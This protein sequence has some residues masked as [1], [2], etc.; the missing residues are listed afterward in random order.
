MKREIK[1]R[2]YAKHDEKMV[3]DIQNI[4]SDDASFGR[5]F[6]QSGQWEVMQFTGLLDKNGNEIYEGDI[7]DSET[8][9]VIPWT[10]EWVDRWAKYTLV[11]RKRFS[12]R[13]HINM[14]IQKAP[15]LEIIGNVVETPDLLK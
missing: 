9:A 3:Y 14:S 2:G 13:S 15:R 1:F 12:N 6:L 8:K 11:G 4:H 10:V 5:L 7:L